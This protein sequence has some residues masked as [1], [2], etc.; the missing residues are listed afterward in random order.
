MIA[1]GL[2]LLQVWVSFPEYGSRVVLWQRFMEEH[3]VTVDSVKLNIST[4]ARAG[5]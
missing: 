3:G 5:S 2:Q 1:I 4:L